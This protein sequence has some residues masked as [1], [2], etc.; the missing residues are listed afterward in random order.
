MKI[1]ILT[2]TFQTNYGCILQ[3]YA[4][5][6]ILERMGHKVEHLQEKDTNTPLHPIWKMPFVW[7]KRLLRKYLGGDK[8]LPI[9]ANPY[10]F[11]RRNTD[12]FITS[13]IHTRHLGVDE[14]SAKLAQDYDV[15]VFGSDQI[16]RPIYAK[17]LERYFGSFI[18]TSPIK[19]IAYAASFG[20]D[21]NE[22]SPEQIQRSSALLSKFDAISVREQSAVSI[23]KERFGVKAIHVLDPTLLL[24]RNDYISF[25]QNA[26]I[27]LSK[28]TLG[29][30]VL[31]ENVQIQAF[32]DKISRQKG[33]KPFCM[34]SKVEDVYAPIS[35]RIH[36]PVEQWIR[37]FYDAEFI[38]TDSFH[39]TVFSILF[40][41]PFVCV[42]NLSRGMSRF[43]SLLNMFKLEECLVDISQLNEFSFLDIDWNIVDI[44][45]S[46][47]RK[48]V[49]MFL[50]TTLKSF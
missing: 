16:W 15:I 34:G 22:Y 5:Q 21:D 18:E 33:L 50:E 41:K 40:H 17:P 39:G 23:C 31:D 29:V 36:P 38:V 46:N 19:R 13:Y 2:F 4:L 27:P 20:T 47:K 35:D 9:F 24:D 32:V 3:A 12:A 11:V 6:T 10:K 7:C 42:G 1:A 25:I 49:K 44:I 48:E 30:Y 45:L 28:G 8:E 14:W 37:A 43:N 26:A